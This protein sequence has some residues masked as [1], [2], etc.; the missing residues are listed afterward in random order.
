L[1]WAELLL[2]VSSP[3]PRHH[4]AKPQF[5]AFQPPQARGKALL[6]QDQGRGT[7]T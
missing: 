6:E 3:R 2:P 4:A 1:G 5:G 7:F